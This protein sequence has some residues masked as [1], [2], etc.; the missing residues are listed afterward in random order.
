MKAIHYGHNKFDASQFKPI[1]NQG[2]EKP[3]GGLWACPE[4]NQ[5]D[6]INYAWDTWG[7]I[8]WPE[9][10]IELEIGEHARVLVI[11]GLEDLNRILKTTKLTWQCWELL[12]FEALSKDYDVI[13]LTKKGQLETHEHGL[14]AWDV[15]T[16]LIMNPEAMRVK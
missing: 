1:Q 4:H 3:A 7:R 11:D 12:D 6:W 14:F 8:T 9:D 16:V 2:R 13:H 15:E 10:R 5:N